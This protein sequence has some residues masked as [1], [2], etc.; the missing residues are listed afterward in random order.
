MA[1]RRTPLIANAWYVAASGAEITRMPLARRIIGRNVVLFRD[2]A[3]APIA[4]QNRC[5]HRSFPLSEGRLDGDTLVC[6]YHGLRYD[7]SGRCVEVPSQPRPPANVGV[8][9]YPLRERGP[10][11]WIWTGD[12]EHADESLLPHQHWLDSPDWDRYHG[13]LHIKASYVHMH[14]NLL[15]LSHLSFLHETTFGT[16]EYA[17]A[18]I[19]STVEEGRYEVWRHVEC[20]LPAI[21]SRPLGWTGERAVRSSGAEYVA[22]GLH[23]NTGR[24]RNVARPAATRDVEPIVKVAQLLTPE[25]NDTTHYYYCLARNFARGDEAMTEFMRK[26][27]YAAFSEDVYALEQI[28][29]MQ[30]TDTDPEFHEID[31]HVDRPGVEMRR[32]LKKLAD[33]EQV[34]G[35]QGS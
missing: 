20:E 15:D 18:P 22:P 30:D 11:V 2:T 1:D 6:R 10:F 26:A 33:A 29:A 35:G 19:E 5:C 4:L 3:G 21:Y 13:Y 27:Q 8:K 17:R 32:H 16:P 9:A 25:T 12:P 23:V 34:Q 24:F 7:F 28:R 14:E 31:V